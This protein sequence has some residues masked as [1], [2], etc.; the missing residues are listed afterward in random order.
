MAVKVTVTEPLPGEGTDVVESAAETVLGKPLV[1][2][3]MA[4]LKAP[5]CADVSV[6]AAVF[7]WAT[8][9]VV[10]DGVTVNVVGAVTVS[11]MFRLVE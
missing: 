8:L 11:G 5:L 1:E 7:P 2:K 10:A 9:M 6:K 4:L 3:P